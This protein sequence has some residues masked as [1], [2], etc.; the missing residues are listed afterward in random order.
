MQSSI[1]SRGIRCQRWVLMALAIVGMGVVSVPVA[2]ADAPAPNRGIANFEVRFME[3]MIDHHALA[4]EMGQ[5][6]LQKAVHPELRQMC[7]NVITTQSQEIE[8]MQSWLQEWY[9]IN[10][11]PQMK[12]GDQRML[13]RL[14]ALSGSEFEIEF[15]QMLIRHHETAIREAEQCVRR[16][17]HP[18]LRDLCQNI[19][20]TQSAEIQQLQAWLCQWYGICRGRQRAG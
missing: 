6:C 5:I 15:M 11:E 9:G 10:Y 12:P 4:I 18:E 16:A 2:Q 19:I 13:Q 1:R 20:Q 8:E 17:Y 3:S 14:A 7:Q